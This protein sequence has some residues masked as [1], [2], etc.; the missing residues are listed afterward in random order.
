M[1]LVLV[2]VAVIDVAACAG[3]QRPLTATVAATL[4]GRRVAMT[5]R[6]PTPFTVV[7]PQKT[8]AVHPAMGGAAGGLVGAMIVIPARLDAG[9]RIMRENA[10]TDPRSF[11]IR[12]MSDDL[13]RHFSLV[14]ERQPVQIRAEDPRQLQ[15]AHPTSDLILDVWIDR[16]TL[17]PFPRFPRPSSKYR[18]SYTA[19]VR[20]I[21]VKGGA[22]IAEGTCRQVPEETPSS[23]TFDEFMANNAQRLKADLEVMTRSCVAEF[24]SKVLNAGRAH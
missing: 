6:P 1:R 13:Q 18:L 15:V 23:P 2:I 10:I 4:T 21:D 14:L 20:L 11:I 8:S 7:E 3:R 24:R 12:Q 22:D 17:E 19:H 5:D 9:W 16:W